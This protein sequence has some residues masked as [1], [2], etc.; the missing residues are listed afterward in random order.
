MISSTENPNIKKI[1]QLNQKTKARRTN[2][3]FVAEGVKMFLEAPTERIYRVYLSESFHR[4]CMAEEPADT[5]GGKG[6]LNSPEEAARA[7]GGRG[8]LLSPE[9]ALNAA[10]REKLSQVSWEIVTDPV[11]GRMT[12][13][14]TPQGI[15][16]VVRIPDRLPEEILRQAGGEPLYLI[17]EAV[18]DPGN[19]G[20]I[21]R[22]AEGAGVNGVFLTK[23][24]VDV[25]SPKVIRS[26]MGSIYRVPVMIVEDVAEAR[27][28]LSPLGVKLAAA[29]LGGKKAYDEV[30]YLG[31]TAFLIGNEARGLSEEAAAAADL[32]IRIPMAGQ[33]ESL[34]AAVSAAVLMYEAARQRRRKD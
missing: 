22:T 13:T 31:G 4:E 6:G 29:H 18:Q 25:T 30:S 32:L 23:G 15:L 3:L 14:V 19:L 34:N 9:N 12:D 1:I 16:T 2:G 28:L 17:L 11:F 21:L 10:A 27:R 5:T 7:A 24:C 33:V 8:G 20:T 26:T